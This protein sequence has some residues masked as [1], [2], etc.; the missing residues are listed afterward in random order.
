MR[1]LA[2][3]V[4]LYEEGLM[5]CSYKHLSS[6]GQDFGAQPGPEEPCTSGCRFLGWASLC[7]SPWHA[8]CLKCDA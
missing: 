1:W 6:A 5:P 4:S 7:S 3:L 2:F 8:V